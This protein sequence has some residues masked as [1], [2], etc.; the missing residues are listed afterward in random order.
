[1]DEIV[2]KALGVHF[3]EPLVHFEVSY[4][5]KPA[6]TKVKKPPAEALG[7]MKKI[8]RKVDEEKQ[9]GTAFA[10]MS[11]AEKRRLDLEIVPKINLGL[12]LQ[13]TKHDLASRPH[14]QEVAEVLEEMLQA[15]EKGYTHL[16]PR[17][18]RK[19]GQLLNEAKAQ[20]GLEAQMAAE[21]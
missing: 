9:K 14:Y 16:P 13:V 2:F 18:H 7:Y 19:P 12:K 1:M 10:Q 5:V 6:I 17:P 4:K 20:R 11:A 15:V 3:L 8:E 21:Q